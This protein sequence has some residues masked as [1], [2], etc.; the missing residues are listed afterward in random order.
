MKNCKGLP[1]IIFMISL[2]LTSC[3]K[4]E[5][6]EPEQ[7]PIEIVVMSGANQKANVGTKL[8]KP[9]VIAVQYAGGVLISFADV[10]FETDDGTVTPSQ[11][12][13]L[14]EGTAQADWVLGKPA[15]KQM[16]NVIVKTQQ[17]EQVA[18]KRI[19]ATAKP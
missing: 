5:T 11:T 12:K 4:G 8:P 18:K 7:A 17:G 13:T 19:N 2:C 6:T 15:G 1:L 14:Q 9:I 16:L 10:S 3:E